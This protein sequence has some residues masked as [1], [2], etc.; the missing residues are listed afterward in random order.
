MTLPVCPRRVKVL[1]PLRA[2][3]IVTVLNRRGREPLA[4][5]AERDF[6]TADQYCR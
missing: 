2:S 4:V 1:W 5:G 6:G 3:A